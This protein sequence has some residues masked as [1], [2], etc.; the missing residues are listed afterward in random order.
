MCPNHSGNHLTD[1]VIKEG[2]E[3]GVVLTSTGTTFDFEDIINELFFE[4]T[5]KAFSSNLKLV[6][7]YQT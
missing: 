4:Y 1:Q 6:K 7:M 3:I 2:I 5:F